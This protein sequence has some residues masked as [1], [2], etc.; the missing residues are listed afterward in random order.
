MSSANDRL[1][2]IIWIC[3]YG[4]LLVMGLGLAVWG[5]AATWPLGLVLGGGG[6]AALGV[7]LIAVRARRTR[8]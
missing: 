2:R 1:D 5:E 6:V 8:R 3:I 4:G 7:V